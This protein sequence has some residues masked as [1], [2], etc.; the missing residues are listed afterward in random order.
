MLASRPAQVPSNMP[1]R[2][3]LDFIAV[4]KAAT[5]FQKYARPI[6]KRMEKRVSSLSELINE[7]GHKGIDKTMP[8]KLRRAITKADAVMFVQSHIDQQGAKASHE[9]Q[10]ATGFL[11]AAIG[12]VIR[13]KGVYFKLL[14][15]EPGLSERVSGCLVNYLAFIRTATREDYMASV[16]E[17][18]RAK[19]V[20]LELTRS[21]VEGMESHFPGTYGW[22]RRLLHEEEK[23]I[24]A[25]Q[26]IKAIF[27][28]KLIYESAVALQEVLK[29]SAPG[30]YGM[31]KPDAKEATKVLLS[32]LNPRSVDL[33][34]W[35]I[36]IDLADMSHAARR[37]LHHLNIAVRDLCNDVSFY[38]QGVD[39]FEGIVP[40]LDEVIRSDH[41]NVNNESGVVTH[42]IVNTSAPAQAM[43][44]YMEAVVGLGYSL[45]PS[46]QPT[47]RQ[48]YD[49]IV[50]NKEEDEVLPAF[51]SW[52]RNLRT[53][54]NKTGCSKRAKRVNGHSRSAITQFEVHDSRQGRA[55]K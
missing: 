12:K 5:D 35:F 18:V 33:H 51:E 21:D 29:T 15:E 55:E 50:E 32:S 37:V 28:L 26:E 38:R 42:P 2:A 4:R 10:V 27:D 14:K 44:R 16:R 30:T 48:A 9:S 23:P 46:A 22:L 20:E 43:R 36:E 40:L 11:S 7:L 8:T 39:R 6:F 31:A 49:W 54:R 13:K 3:D 41:E 47:D 17:A 45:A 34:D 52:C 19:A 25:D 1:G 53:V 24:E